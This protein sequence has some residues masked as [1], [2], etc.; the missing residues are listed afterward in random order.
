MIAGTK[1][2]W[3]D[4]EIRQKLIDQRTGKKRS[5]QSKD[6]LSIGRGG[7]PFKV[8]KGPELVGTWQNMRQCARDLGFTGKAQIWKCLNG[9]R[10]SHKE[11]RFEYE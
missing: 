11:F 3:N 10:K 7:R 1:R 8:F 4:P 9:K 6:N 2:Q 5:N